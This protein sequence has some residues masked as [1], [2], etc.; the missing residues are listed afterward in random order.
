MLTFNQMEKSG[1]RVYGG[2]SNVVMS[3]C[4][5]RVGRLDVELGVNMFVEVLEPRSARNYG[6]FCRIRILFEVALKMR[7]LWQ[8]PSQ[9]R[10]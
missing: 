2:C 1:E 6:L 9:P 10:I 3:I 7:Q 5:T 8:W 4:I